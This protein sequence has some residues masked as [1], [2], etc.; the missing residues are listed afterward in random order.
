MNTNILNRTIM[1]KNIIF[2]IT[3]FILAVILASCGSPK[4]GLKGEKEIIQPCVGEDYSTGNGF[5]R[6]TASVLDGDMSMAKKRATSAARAEVATQMGAMIKRVTDDYSKA[7]NENSDQRFEDRA[8][9]VVKQQLGTTKIICDKLMRTPDG[10]FRAYICV[11]Y[12]L[13]DALQSI[14]DK[15]KNDQELRMDFQYEKFKKVFEDEM[16]Q[17]GQQK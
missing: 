4:P 9:T 11:E 15:I 5:V 16:K 2:S 17:M 7:I 13:K 8:L 14:G 6:A 3:V 12:D 1:K 10:K